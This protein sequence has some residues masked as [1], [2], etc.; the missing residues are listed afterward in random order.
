LSETLSD[1]KYFFVIFVH[2]N[3][4]YQKMLTVEKC[5]CCKLTTGSYILN[6][7]GIVYALNY[8]ISFAVFSTQYDDFIGFLN[9]TEPV[10]AENLI[11][12]KSGGS[13]L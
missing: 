2:L 11:E 10:L 9:K 8:L 5:C 7:A 1:L 6:I 12:H 13:S 3:N 4:F